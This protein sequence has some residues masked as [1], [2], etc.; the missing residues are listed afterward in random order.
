MA[1]EDT[2]CTIQPYFKIHEG[3]IAEFKA[4]AERMTAET[5]SEDGCLYYGFSYDGDEAYCREGYADAEGLLHHAG[6]LRELLDELM[7]YCDI[8]RFEVCGP[9]AQLAKLKEPMAEM[10][11]RYFVLEKGFRR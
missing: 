3:R 5:G 7:Q 9:E 6:H 1:A 8:A 2:C 4:V 10:A 11:P